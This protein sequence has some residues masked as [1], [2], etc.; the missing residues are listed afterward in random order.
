MQELIG[1]GSAV[2]L[3]PA[4]ATQTY[5]QCQSRHEPVSASALWFFVLILIG[6]VG[7]AVYSG[8]VGNKVY[9][10]LNSSL[11]VNNT[12]GLVIAIAR[13]REAGPE[14]PKS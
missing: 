8:M 6:T 2:I 4:F 1:W 12:I 3:V 10:V 5:R 11:V 7:Q 9:L 14:A 13:Y